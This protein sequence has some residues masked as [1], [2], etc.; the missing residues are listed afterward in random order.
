M[1][2]H[3]PTVIP[4]PLIPP[5]ALIL[6]TGANGLIASH[7][8]SQLL[9]F[10]YRVRGTVRS[11]THCAYLTTLFDM[12]HGPGRFELLEVPERGASGAWDAAVRGVSGVAHVLGSVDLVV[13][14]AD[15]AAAEEM[16]WQVDLLA[17]AAKEEGVRSVVFT[18]SAWAAW[19]PEGSK[20]VT[21]TEESWKDDAVAL[22]RDGSVDPRSKGLAGF[23]ALKALI[24]KGVWEWVR[25]EKPS[26]VFNTVLLDTVF[27]ECLDP[28]NQGIP[29]TAGMVRWVWENTN[30]DTLNV[31]Q[32]QWFVD[33]R[34]TGRLY[35]ALLAITPV[36]SGERIFGFG[37]RYSSFFRVAKILK[38]LY[39]EHADRLAEVKDLGGAELLACVGQSTGWRSL[40]ESIKENVESLL[41]LSG[42]DQERIGK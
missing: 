3:K 1:T 32:Q 26:Y 23:M 31:M 14:D 40:E 30:A 33:C 19:A 10:G 12:R 4:N 8:A 39:P 25:R 16:P 9:A 18:S 5:D 7:V 35:V 2:T 22:A 15:A 37:E 36:V 11:A 29:S 34:D 6:V 38:E 27:G 42:G 21:L 13:R 41:K 17:A 24:E 28:V 20:R